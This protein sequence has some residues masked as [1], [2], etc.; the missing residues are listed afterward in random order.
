MIER[1]K[2]YPDYVWSLRKKEDGTCAVIKGN[3]LDQNETFCDT[4]KYDNKPK[5]P[6]CQFGTECSKELEPSPPGECWCRDPSYKIC[7]HKSVCFQDTCR[8]VCPEF[9]KQKNKKCVCNKSTLCA[10]SELCKAGQCLATPAAC[11]DLTYADPVLGCSCIRGDDG[12]ICSQGQMC[13]EQTEDTAQCK[14]VG[15]CPINP[16]TITDELCYCNMTNTVCQ[17]GGVCDTSLGRCVEKCPD[18]PDPNPESYCKCSTS[19]TYCNYQE[20]CGT[21]G[22]APACPSMP[23]EAPGTGCYC[24]VTKCSSGDTCELTEGEGRCWPDVAPCPGAHISISE[25]ACYC[26][27][28]GS[29]CRA[30][31][32]C[33]DREDACT[34]PHPLCPT[35]PGLTE[36]VCVCLNTSLCAD[37][38]LCSPEGVC[39]TP[40]SCQNVFTETLELEVKTEDPQLTEGHNVSLQCN[41]CHHVPG[42]IHV[43]DFD[44]YCKS[45]GMWNIS[46]TACTAYP[47][48]DLSVDTQSVQETT[49]GDTCHRARN[50]KCKN[51][52]EYFERAYGEAEVT[53]HCTSGGWNTTEMSTCS[54][55]NP[56]NA[57]LCTTPHLLKCVFKV[58]TTF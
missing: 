22:C 54:V 34:E 3:G 53:F 27:S 20:I 37:G 11:T 55:V 31:Q 6:I 38:Q 51:E 44:V 16:T 26:S 4:I 36:A 56:E 29:L 33:N 30:G 45:D 12:E 58:F 2:S 50:F 42:N 17:A 43:R 15:V 35:Y 9:P 41:E 8:H 19:E 48:A 52:M 10:A 21:S 7:W 18:H 24:G 57:D 32:I 28:S 47:C 23:Q 39:R 1:S 46:I 40:V 49:E 5:R 13:I 14:D 25:P